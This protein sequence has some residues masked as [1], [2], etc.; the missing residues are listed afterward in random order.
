MRMFTKTD[1]NIFK[2]DKAR[3][4]LSSKSNF[5]HSLKKFPSPNKNYVNL[6]NFQDRI[7]IF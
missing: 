2:I 1:L 6:V 5:C 3:T 7:E 4:V